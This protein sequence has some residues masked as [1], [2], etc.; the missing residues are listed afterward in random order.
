M[1]IYT[2]VVFTALIDCF[3]L[4]QVPTLVEIFGMALVIGA[5]II[6]IRKTSQAPSGQPTESVKDYRRTVRKALRPVSA[7]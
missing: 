3:L 5:G 7:A 2:V 1:T 6:A 4:N